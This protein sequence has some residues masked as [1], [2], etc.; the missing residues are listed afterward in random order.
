MTILNPHDTRIAARHLKYDN[1]AQERENVQR[2]DREVFDRVAEYE[3]GVVAS[4][5]A[6][7]DK[8]DRLANEAVAA[9]ADLNSRFRAAAEDG[10]VTRDLLREFNR[11]RA[12]AEALADSLNVAERTAQWHAGRLSDVYGTWLAL[13]QKYPTLKPGIRVQ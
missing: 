6:D 2:V 3:R 8:G 5:R 1:T 11:V 12:Q 4:A 10:N 13:V 7:A 9:V